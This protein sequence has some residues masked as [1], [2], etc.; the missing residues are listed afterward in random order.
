METDGCVVKHCSEGFKQFMVKCALF[1]LLQHK[2]HDAR[3]EYQ[4][5]SREYADIFDLTT[6]VVYE[7]HHQIDHKYTNNPLV[8]EKITINYKKMPDDLTR[9]KKQLDEYIIE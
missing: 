9:L 7:I 3:T 8:K 4:I 2:K 5:S 1:Y 6:M